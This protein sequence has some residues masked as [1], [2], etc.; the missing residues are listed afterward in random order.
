MARSMSPRGPA[1]WPGSSRS[2]DLGPRHAPVGM[3]N[4]PCAVHDPQEPTTPVN[5][6]APAMIRT[7]RRS[8]SPWERGWGP[9]VRAPT[10]SVFRRS[11]ASAV[12]PH[13][14]TLAGVVGGY[15]ELDSIAG[16][17]PNQATPTHLARC[18]GRDFLTGVELHLERGVSKGGRHHSLRPKD[19]VRTCHLVPRARLVHAQIT[20]AEGVAVELSDRCLGF[21]SVRHLN[22]TKSARSARLTI[23]DDGGRID[24][25]VGPEEGL[26]VG[27]GS[28]ERDVPDV[29]I[30]SGAVAFLQWSIGKR[31]RADPDGTGLRAGAHRQDSHTRSPFRHTRRSPR[32]NASSVTRPGSIKRTTERNSPRGRRPCCR[33]GGQGR[34]R[35]ARMRPR[36]NC[37]V[38]GCTAERRRRRRG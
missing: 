5:Q 10:S 23:S 12:P 22:E 31:R 17:D 29:D 26:E 34:L 28:A 18:P 4:R 3:S 14:P 25:T 7:V 9:Q 24:R 32:C 16:N 33:L 38:Q 30:H 36:K 35:P 37:D 21:F 2:A 11:H 19:I 27:L 1:S 6:A 20:A 13:D 15:L 8:A